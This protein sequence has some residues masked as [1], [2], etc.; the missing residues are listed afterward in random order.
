MPKTQPKT[1]P[2]LRGETLCAEMQPPPL[3]GEPLREE[4]LQVLRGRQLRVAS[5]LSGV[6]AAE[7]ACKQQGLPMGP[8]VFCSELSAPLQRFLACQYP[9]TPIFGNIMDRRYSA[10]GITGEAFVGPAGWCRKVR[11]V[12]EV[13][14]GSLD[15]YVS[16]RLVECRRGP[17]N[18][19]QQLFCR[20]LKTVATL[21]PSVA[22]VGFAGSPSETWMDAVRGLPR[23]DVAMGTMNPHLYGVPQS[24][25]IDFAV[26]VRKSG[27]ADPT[28]AAERAFALA[29][30]LRVKNTLSWHE[31][32]AD[33]GLEVVPQTAAAAP[34]PV[35]TPCRAGISGG[36]CSAG[37][38]GSAGCAP[39]EFTSEWDMVPASVCI[40][41]GE[42]L[43][44]RF[45]LKSV[46]SEHPCPCG[47]C[48]RG[49]MTAGRAEATSCRWRMHMRVLAAKLAPNRIKYLR[50]WRRAK[51]NPTLKRVPNYWELVTARK[52]SVPRAVATDP[53]VRM[54]LKMHSEGRNLVA[55]PVM[56]DLTGVDSNRQMRLRADGTSLTVLAPC[57]KLFAPSAGVFLNAEQCF[58]LGGITLLDLNAHNARAVRDDQVIAYTWA[59]SV[60]P[61]QVVGPLILAAL[62]VVAGY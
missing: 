43:P 11:E 3:R 6:G 62:A 28:G 54:F 49:A 38:A 59:G 42:G 46:C 27:M 12:R 21:L 52:L 56:C 7:M 30:R 8:P 18:E 36:A 33:K 26:L 47:D 34:Q 60:L 39:T 32:L 57:T 14:P 25:S 48:H 2:P 5:D 10:K 31:H 44:S 22:I 58:A 20:V 15:L 4:M 17:T 16:P 24:V 35:P 45:A 40:P 29:R 19:E 23:Y 1:Q 53:R 13:A 9:T 37:S 61:P 51:G 41:C 55:K 50:V